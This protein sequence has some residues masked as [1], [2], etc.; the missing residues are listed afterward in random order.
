MLLSVCSLWSLPGIS[1]LTCISELAGELRDYYPVCINLTCHLSWETHERLQDKK[2][3]VVHGRNLLLNE[4]FPDKF[5]R[6][7]NQKLQARGIELVLGDYVAKFPETCG[8]EVIFR[9]GKKLRADLVVGTS[10]A[11]I[12]LSLLTGDGNVSLRFRLT[13]PN[14][15]HLGYP[16][17]WA[18]TL[19]PPGVL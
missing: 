15:I 18:R 8:G 6:L 7:V 10:L 1:L 16:T 12:G 4:Q 14:R 13:D 2:V 19:F 9:S 5:R 3:V 11:S 17:L